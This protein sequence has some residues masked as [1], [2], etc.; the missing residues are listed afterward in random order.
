MRPCCAGDRVCRRHLIRQP[1]RQCLARQVDEIRCGGVGDEQVICETLRSAVRAV[2]VAF[3]TIEV[4]GQLGTCSRSRGACATRLFDGRI[5]RT[6]WP[7]H[8]PHQVPKSGAPSARGHGPGR[9]T[10]G[11]PSRPRL[12]GPPFMLSDSARCPFCSICPSYRRTSV[13]GELMPG[14]G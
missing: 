11:R 10:G 9:W 8:L 14:P 6:L 1:P 13:L 4:T 3:C 2:E 5:A 12:H 7:F